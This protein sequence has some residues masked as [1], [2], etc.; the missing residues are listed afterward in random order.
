MIRP[1][2]LESLRAKGE[3]QTREERE[4]RRAEWLGVKATAGAVRWLE[5]EGLEGCP[6]EAKRPAR[7]KGI[8]EPE[9]HIHRAGVR[10]LIVAVKPGNAGGAKGC[11][12]MET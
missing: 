7:C 12:K 1:D 5:T 4:A 10:A 2:C 11:R 9:W 6:Y 3:P 8:E